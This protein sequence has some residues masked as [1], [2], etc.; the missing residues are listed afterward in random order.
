MQAQIRGI[1]KLD[2]ENGAGFDI[3][4]RVTDAM[5]TVDEAGD[6]DAFID[7]VLDAGRKGP[8]KAEEM[9]HKPFIP[10]ELSWLKSA[11][12]YSKGGFGVYVVC[13]F[14][15]AM[16]KEEGT[17]KTG[18]PNVVTAMYTFD[19]RGVFELD[20]PRAFVI[21]DKDTGNGTMYYLERA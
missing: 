20:P 2:E 4:Q 7:G 9:L 12:K 15:D 8:L 18:A 5:L 17:F 19:Q 16:T 10:R 13:T 6:I 21:R 14:L 3:A 1:A 11:E